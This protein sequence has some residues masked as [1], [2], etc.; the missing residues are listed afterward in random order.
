MQI[1]NSEIKNPLV[2][3]N[4]RKEMKG[5]KNQLFIWRKTLVE[6]SLK[7]PWFLSEI[8]F[9]W[10]RERIRGPIN[11]W[12]TRPSKADG[13]P[14]CGWASSNQLMAWIDQRAWPSPEWKGTP[15]T[16][17]LELEHCSFSSD[18][19]GNISSPWLLDWN[20]TSLLPDLQLADSRS[21]NVSV[22]IIMWVN[23][24]S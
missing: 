7:R 15:P 12:I 6:S 18:T 20:Y 14:Y 2:M 8:L 23:F 22:S 10:S 24:L 19:N 1:Q 9:S 11:I 4:N 3:F 5:K 16:W 21:W 13:L 17:L